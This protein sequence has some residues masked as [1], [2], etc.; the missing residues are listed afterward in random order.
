MQPH[1]I[2][3]A[4]VVI[5]CVAQPIFM[6]EKTTQEFYDI[7][8]TEGELEDVDNFQQVYIE[9]RGLF[10]VALDDNELIGTG[11]LKKLEDNIAELKQVWLLEEYRGQKIGYQIVTQLLSFARTKGYSHVRLRTSQKQQRAIGFYTRIGF[12]E[13]PSYR[14]SLNNIIS[15]ELKL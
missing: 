15:M 12:Y 14:K 10:L 3:D 5:S 7:M 1:Q 11:A 9:D 6:P 13:I 8:E 2:T 4:K